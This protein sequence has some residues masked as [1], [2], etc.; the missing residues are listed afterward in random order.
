MEIFGNTLIR[1]MWLF[2]LPLTGTG[3]SIFETSRTSKG[4]LVL[5]TLQWW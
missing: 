2:S 3:K 1:Q 4:N 5:M